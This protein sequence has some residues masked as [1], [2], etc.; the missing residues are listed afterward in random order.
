MPTCFPLLGEVP[1]RGDRG[2]RLKIEIMRIYQHKLV[3]YAREMRKQMTDEEK[4]LWFLFLRNLPVKFVRQRSFGYYVVDFYCAKANLAIEIDGSQHYDAE[5]EEYDIKR[6]EFL[7]K[8]GITVVRYSNLQVN[9][10]FEAVQ[11]DI[12]QRLGLE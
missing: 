8:Q 12:L 4:K 3:Q 9:R 5:R 11:A 10:E 6:D 7:R 1:R 2:S